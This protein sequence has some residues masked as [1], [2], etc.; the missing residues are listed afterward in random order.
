LL[1]L[2]FLLQWNI[3]YLKEFISPLQDQLT[4]AEEYVKK[5]DWETAKKM[6]QEVHKT[7]KEKQFYLHVTLRHSDIDEVFILLEQAEA[8]LEHKKIGEYAAV[9]KAVIGQL[10]LLIEME[11]LTL[12]NI[13]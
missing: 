13:L 7:W 9:N 3:H 12:R 2:F 10:D 8:Y 4:Q 5:D 6:T 1:G 11:E